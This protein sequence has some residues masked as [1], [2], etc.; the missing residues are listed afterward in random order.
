MKIPATIDS[1]ISC[2]S[3]SRPDNATARSSSIP[4]PTID[5]KARSARW[6]FSY[7]LI[8]YRTWSWRKPV[9]FTSNLSTDF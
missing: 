3:I 6:R 9:S 1:F 2:Y 8:S 4:P 5:W 7:A